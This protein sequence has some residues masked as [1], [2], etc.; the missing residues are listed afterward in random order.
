LQT[1]E[2]LFYDYDFDHANVPV[3]RHDIRLRRVTTVPQSAQSFNQRQEYMHSL[4]VISTI[5]R[6]LTI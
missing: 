2:R 6:I 5:L 3:W 1:K 4:Q